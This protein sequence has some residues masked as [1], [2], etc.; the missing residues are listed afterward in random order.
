MKLPWKNPELKQEIENLQ[1]SIEDKDQ[2]IEKLENM[3]EAEKNRRKKH[4]REKQE[5]QE[6]VN[7]L[8]D[9]L[10]GLKEKEEVNEK[11]EVS[12]IKSQDLSLDDFLSSLEK[13]GSIEADKSELMTVYSPE[14]LSNHSNIQDIKSTVPEDKLEELLNLEKLLIFYDPDLGLSV[15]KS[16]PFYDERSTVGKSFEVEKLLGFIAEEKIWVLVSRGETRI[17][18]EKD[19]EVE[20]LEEVKSRVNSK[21]GKGGFS[22]GRFERKRDEQVDQHLEQVEKQIKGLENIYLLGEETLCKELPGQRLGGFDPN[23]SPLENFYRP[24]KIK[25]SSN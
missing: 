11:K 12:E 2:Q 5:A 22:Q 20:K 4:T 18:S 15:F 9:Q 23:L 24:R 21:H 3:L 10:E 17:Y 19:G 14:K 16:T 13:L 8:E 25:I 1:A 6:K 7:R